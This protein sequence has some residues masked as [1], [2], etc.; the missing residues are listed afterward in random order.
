MYA[1][2]ILTG[3]EAV[4]P[5]FSETMQRGRFALLSFVVVTLAG[6]LITDQRLDTFKAEAGNP[7]V[8]VSGWRPFIGWVCGLGCAWNWIGLPMAKA[9]M[10]LVVI[11]WA[12]DHY[13]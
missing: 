6:W 10:V 8:F 5:L 1:A 12:K 11:A 4:L 2:S 9:A 3:C 7:S 13:K